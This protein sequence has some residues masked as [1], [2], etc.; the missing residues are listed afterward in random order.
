MGIQEDLRSFIN[1]H[2]S[3]KGKAFT[4]TS[5]A[6]PKVSLFIS[7]EEYEEFIN[8]YALAIMNG[9]P[10][11]FTEKPIDPS[12]IRI[13]LDF[14]FCLV[15]EKIERKYNDINIYNII[16]NYFILINKY[17]DLSDEENY[18]Y[19]MEKSNPTEY[20]NKIK[21]GI[22]IVFPNIIASNN[23]QHFIRKKILDI[24]NELF[25]DLPICNEYE[26]I[27]DKAIITSN[28]WQMYGSKKP[29]CEAYRVSKIYFYKDNKT[30]L[31]N[32]T[33]QAADEIKYISLFS[34]KKKAD[35]SKIK[36]EHV[37]EIEEY[38]KHVLPSIDKS[39]KDK[40]ENN[41]LFNKAIH[42]NKNYT[43]E[44]ELEL[45]RILV[46]ECLSHT[47]AEKYDDWITLGWVLR[48]IDYR[49]LPTWI[50]FSKISSSYIEGECQRLWDKMRKDHMGMGTLRWWAKNDNSRRYN[51][52]IDE[53]I[54][55]LIDMAINSQ[56]AH[57]DIAKVI[58]AQ[59]KDEYKAVSKD[60]WFKYDKRKHRWVK[61]R[62]GLYLRKALSDEICKKFIERSQYY[63]YQSLTANSDPS[64]LTSKAVF[65]VR[66]QE[67][68]KIALKL[69][70]A[71]FKDHIMKECK[72]LFIDEK[73]EEML[74]SRKH[75]IGFE[76]GVY[77]LKM[78]IFREGMP[79]DYISFSTY[80]NYI[81]YN[82]N[83]PEI[84]EINDFFSKL[85]TNEAIRNYVLDIL[86]CIIDGS[87]TQERFYIFTGQGSNGKSRLLDLIQKTVGDY[88]S[89]LPISLLTQKR[90]ASNA[91]QSEVERTKGRRFAVLS[92][93]NENDKINIGYMKELSGNDKILTRGLYKDPF[94][95]TPQFTM[96]LACNE[97]PEIPSD[98]GGT[99]RRIRVI[100][101]LSK[102][103]ENPTKPN[104]FIM[105]MELT[106][107]FERYS[108]IFMTMLIERHKGINPVKIHEPREVV[109]ATQKYKNNNDII[110]QY[111]HD[112]I[113]KDDNVKEKLMIMEIY[114]DFKIWCSKNIIK[115]KKQPDRNQL[116]SYFEKM[117][118][119]YDKGWKLK[120][121]TEDNFIIDN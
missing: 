57:Y 48:N 45:A 59:Y 104:E 25:K 71:S 70:N 63:N 41:I 81:P 1:K 73:F 96:I 110:G 6:N 53:A 113:I 75:L 99:W 109:N 97:L 119:L 86:C 18:A 10:L 14:R 74:D 36:P 33:I 66:A 72:C 89:T 19:I 15:N 56:G 120:F 31:L 76:N 114:G 101:F 47:R 111:V 118:G 106:E 11:Y 9:I 17:L 68:Q 90:A 39:K 62:E 78:H 49:L 116:R 8:L 20:R 51:E 95:F 35:I 7:D 37:L 105:D 91:A 21:D 64:T 100:E 83:I 46:T 58:Q 13:D 54:Y 107:K 40:L 32:F 69:K 38:I 82:P 60:I 79:D 98:D 16:N 26:D 93:P 12:P 85:F 102:F 117:Y 27:I 28:C 80:K 42:I 4:N 23:T 65:E 24:A 121:N 92:E 30:Q 50:E 88:Y 34:M 22:H 55:N 115:S 5:I 52:I 84:D 112:K 43:T 94:E 3:E 44:D 103:C 61:T 2:K 77:D 108:E 67:S 87:I 29:D